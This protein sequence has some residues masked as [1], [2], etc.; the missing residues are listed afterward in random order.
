MNEKELIFMS[1]C[2]NIDAFFILIS[3]YKFLIEKVVK[4][5]SPYEQEDLTNEIIMK[6]Y[7]SID[8]F[9]EEK[10][11]AV[12]IASIARN[13]CIDWLRKRKK[14]V[15]LDIDYSVNGYEE[16]E[17]REKQHILEIAME[18][19]SEKEKA[20]I[21]LHYFEG[22][23]IKMIS[24]RLCMSYSSIKVTLYRAR[25]KIKEQLKKLGYF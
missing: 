11:F 16:I 20:I 1:K 2:K 18:V 22:L 9:D 24:K 5:F 8:K 3:K 12:W 17:K 13:Y 19:L 14:I 6:V 7:E 15:A 10:N 23:P 25:E 4:K 21:I